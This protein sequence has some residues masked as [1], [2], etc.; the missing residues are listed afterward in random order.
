MSGIIIG[1]GKFRLIRGLL[2]SLLAI[3]LAGFCVQF[4]AAQ[5]PGQNGA[6]QH[7]AHHPTVGFIDYRIDGAAP[8]QTASQRAVAGLLAA[9]ESD[10]LE[11]I[12]FIL[13]DNSEVLDH[14]IIN[15]ATQEIFECNS[16]GE[17]LRKS[18]VSSGKRGF[19]TPVGEY[20]IANRALKAY[21]EK[22]EAWMLH[23]MGLTRNGEYGMHGLEGSSYERLLGRVASHGCVRLS[24]EYATNLYARV[25]I[26]MP[27]TIV[28]D[29]S[30]E[31]REY[32]P[33][34]P[35]AAHALVLELLC[36]TDPWE[37]FY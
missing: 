28:D 21:S 20:H 25:Q 6:A 3:G 10:V 33:L 26:G 15:L 12:G 30:L 32:Q 4:P 11:L 2:S 18:K 5:E 19:G 1:M 13:E 31:V 16:K 17:I 23:W 7:Q 14:I 22:Y 27:V 29:A 36:P 24:R 35:R 34:T 37:V 8:Y 9:G